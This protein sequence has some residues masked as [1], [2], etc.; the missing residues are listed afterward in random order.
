MR[1]ITDCGHTVGR[2]PAR[3]SASGAGCSAEQSDDSIIFISSSSG[4]GVSW[5]GSSTTS[6]VTDEDAAAGFVSIRVQHSR[7]KPGIKTLFTGSLSRSASSMKNDALR[8]P[9]GHIIE[10]FCSESAS[11]SASWVRILP[12]FTAFPA[13]SKRYEKE[14]FTLPFS[15]FLKKMVFCMPALRQTVIMRL[16]L[17]QPFSG[18]ASTQCRV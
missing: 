13:A 3:S 17:R 12:E 11:F 5:G 18:E 15:S 1:L 2:L 7:V 4:A 16:I 8:S 6:S 14:R 10:R 9:S